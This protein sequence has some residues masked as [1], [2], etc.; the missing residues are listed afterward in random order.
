MAAFKKA[1]SNRPFVGALLFVVLLY[2]FE[3]LLFGFPQA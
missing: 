1:F 3:E 2:A